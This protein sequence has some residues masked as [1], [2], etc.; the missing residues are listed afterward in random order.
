[1]VYVEPQTVL[2]IDL[3]YFTLSG[4]DSRTDGNMLSFP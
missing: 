3:E 2:V 4:Q 1:M